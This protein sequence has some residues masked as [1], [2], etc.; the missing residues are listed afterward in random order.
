MGSPQLSAK[1]TLYIDTGCPLRDDDLLLRVFF[2]V[3]HLTF[4]VTS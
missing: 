2:R 1:L 3:I 4:H